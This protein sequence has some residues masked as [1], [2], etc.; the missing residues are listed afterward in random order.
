MAG[1]PAHTV[2]TAG[3]AEAGPLTNSMKKASSRLRINEGQT[4]AGRYRI[5]ERIGRGGL[6]VV[7]K[8]E[9]LD[10]QKLVAVKLYLPKLNLD[11]E[12]AQNLASSNANLDKRIVPLIE[13][14]FDE[15]AKLHYAVMPYI[16]G[17]TL[18]DLIVLRGRLDEGEAVLFLTEI[19]SVIKAA[20]DCDITHGDINPG[21]I[22]ICETREAEAP[23]LKLIDFAVHS[24]ANTALIGSPAFM[25]PEQCQ[26]KAGGK[27]SDI[28]ALGSLLYYMVTGASP[29]QEASAEAIILS[30]LAGKHPPFEAMSLTSHVKNIFRN[31]LKRKREERYESIDELLK[32]LALAKGSINIENA[33]LAKGHEKKLPPPLKIAVLVALACIAYA[34]VEFVGKH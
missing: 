17:Q 30:K 2:G 31:T 15:P 7:Y 8:A 16:Q 34:L 23:V 4:F 6:S 29:F 20:H 5:L 24:T 26:G 25:S 11:F 32:D 18:T 28:Y 13:F 3:G 1:Q 21:N 33:H 9:C 10:D 22:I 19:A 27:A 12:K 14:G